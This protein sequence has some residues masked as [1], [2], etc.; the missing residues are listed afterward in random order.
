MLRESGKKKA[1]PDLVERMQ[2]EEIN[3]NGGI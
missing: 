2:M 1:E 3:Q